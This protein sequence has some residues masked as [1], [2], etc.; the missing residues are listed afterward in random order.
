MQVAKSSISLTPQYRHTTFEIL[1][2]SSG[3]PSAFDQSPW[4][5]IGTGWFYSTLGGGSKFRENIPDAPRSDPKSKGNDNTV[6]NETTGVLP[7]VY[8]GNFEATTRPFYGRTIIPDSSW[9]ETPGWAFHGG[10]SFGSHSSTSFQGLPIPT[11]SGLRATIDTDRITEALKE[12]GTL[13]DDV[14]REIQ[15]AL[16]SIMDI[17]YGGDLGGIV[18]TAQSKSGSSP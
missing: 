3:P 14:I 8:N 4:E 1:G 16:S 9:Y 6:W 7:G 17:I 5:G 15:D 2:P 18:E 12:L 13:D 11:Q 10:G